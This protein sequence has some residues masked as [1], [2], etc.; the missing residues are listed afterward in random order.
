MASKKPRPRLEKFEQQDIAHLLRSIGGKVYTLGT[1]RPRGK[2]CPTC[3]TFVAESQGTRQTPGV[4]DLLAFLPTRWS[5]IASGPYRQLMVEAKSEA[6][7]MTP[8][9]KEFRELCLKAGVAHVHGTLDDV[10]AWLLKEGYL[11]PSQVPH[12]R[13]PA[14]FVLQE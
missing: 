6:G 12:Y 14:G 8:E 5:G 3:A 13:V 11:K 7:S 4:A 9:Q 1:R 2:K 10:I